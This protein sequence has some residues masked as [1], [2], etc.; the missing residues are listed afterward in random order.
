MPFHRFFIAS[1][2]LFNCNYHPSSGHSLCH[3]CEEEPPPTRSTPWG[4]YRSQCCHIVVTQSA[5]WS[6]SECSY[7]ST[8]HH[9]QVPIL[10][11]GEA[12]QACSSH[13]AQGCYK[14][15]QLAA[16]RFKPMTCTSRV[17]CTIH[18][19]TTS[20]GLRCPFGHHVSGLPVRCS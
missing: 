20:L 4:A 7:S 3:V 16:L 18:S 10:H 6:H 17:P 19:A 12:R 15:S 11:L 9:S 13:L 8:H 5:Q 2:V 1:E 14:V